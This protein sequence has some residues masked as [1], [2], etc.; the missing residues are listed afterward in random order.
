MKSGIQ[1]PTSLLQGG[2][3]VYLLE[4]GEPKKIVFQRNYITNLNS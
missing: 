3:Q 2:L 4:R 1:P